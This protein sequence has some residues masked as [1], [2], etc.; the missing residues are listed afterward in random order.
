M[1]S[2]KSVYYTFKYLPFAIGLLF[3]AGPLLAHIFPE[4][5]TFNGEPGPPD[6]W[7]TAIFV[8]VGAVLLLIPFLYIWKLVI[9]QLSND[10]IRIKKA[11]EVVEL[12]WLDVDDVRMLP[13]IF[14]PLYKLRIKNYEGYFLFNTGRWGAQ[15]LI[16]TWDWSEMGNLIKRKQ[17]ELG[18]RS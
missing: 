3:I 15:F 8:L 1:E 16:S 11:N 10:M 4:N 17:K 12:T 7:S 5:A 2:D 13:G 6:F 18:M 9:V 14:P